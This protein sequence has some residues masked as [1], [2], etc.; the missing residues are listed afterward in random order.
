MLLTNKTNNK[1]CSS[2]LIKLNYTDTTPNGALCAASS[3]SFIYVAMRIEYEYHS[4]L[5][6]LASYARYPHSDGLSV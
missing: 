1:Q 4:K 2:A 5:A 3:Y 6:A